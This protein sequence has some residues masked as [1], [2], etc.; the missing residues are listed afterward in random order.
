MDTI[1]SPL[2]TDDYPERVLDC[3][4]A[5]E[6]AFAQLLAAATKAGWRDT[7]VAVILADLADDHVLELARTAK[8]RSTN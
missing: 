4:Q 7:E 3:E 6:V 1:F 5:M 2:H 8:A